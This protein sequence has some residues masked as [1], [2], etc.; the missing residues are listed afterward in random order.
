[1][2]VCKT[3]IPSLHHFQFWREYT[4][5]LP[6]EGH[7]VF[8]RGW[9]GSHYQEKVDSVSS[10]DAEIGGALGFSRCA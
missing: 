2:I 6:L 3:L 5:S 8:L 7:L 10:W 9:D 4:A 1:M